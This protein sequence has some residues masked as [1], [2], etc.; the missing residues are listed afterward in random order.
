MNKNELYASLLYLNQE[1]NENNYLKGSTRI[2]N[3]T[4]LA[5]NFLQNVS[6]DLKFKFRPHRYGFFSEEL[7]SDLE[8]QVSQGFISINTNFEKSSESKSKNRVDYQLTERGLKI[9]RKQFKSYS[10]ENKFILFGLRNLSFIKTNRLIAIA[11]YL[12]PNMAIHSKKNPIINQISENEI[13]T[14]L[15]IFLKA[16]PSKLISKFSDKNETFSVFF[17]DM[18][19]NLRFNAIKPPENSEFPILERIISNNNELLNFLANY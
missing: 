4:F 1:L 12:Y 8:S 14:G 3:L 18:K 11:Y 10:P 17:P 2:Q 6:N 16:F 13:H 15:K 9:M 19:N 5:Q 7:K